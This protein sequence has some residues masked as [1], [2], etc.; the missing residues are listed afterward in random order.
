M[1][2]AHGLNPTTTNVTN[3]TPVSLAHRYRR[4]A[5]RR[6]FNPSESDKDLG[7]LLQQLARVAAEER[8]TLLIRR[9]AARRPM[10]A[11]AAAAEAAVVVGRRL[12]QL[13][14][15]RA[16]PLERGD[17][18]QGRLLRV[19]ASPRHAPLV[20]TQE[21]RLDVQLDNLAN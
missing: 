20:A 21:A 6:V 11:R 15:L 13:V 10:A 16:E 8:R 1:L 14:A 2:L 19:E 12:E 5:V 4:A 17:A 3:E 18:A 9:H 7:D